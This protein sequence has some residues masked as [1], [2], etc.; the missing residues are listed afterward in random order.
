[1]LELVVFYW[2]F[3]RVQQRGKQV[4]YKIH[5]SFFVANRKMFY[6]NL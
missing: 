1:M 2:N 4:D 3:Y 6:I 5:C